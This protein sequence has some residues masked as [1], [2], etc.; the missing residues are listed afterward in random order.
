MCPGLEKWWLKQRGNVVYYVRLQTLE[1][2]LYC[3][4]TISGGHFKLSG[5]WSQ[6][7]WEHP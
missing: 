3:L 5:G 7:L 2:I 4:V 6:P 1:M